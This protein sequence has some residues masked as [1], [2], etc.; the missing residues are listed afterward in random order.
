MDMDMDTVLLGTVL[1]ES[2]WECR[3]S[4]IVPAGIVRRTDLS[5]R[6]LSSIARARRTKVD[7][8]YVAYGSIRTMR[9]LRLSRLNE[10]VAKCQGLTFQ[11]TTI[12]ATAITGQPNQAASSSSFAFILTI[13]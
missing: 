5:T 3:C 11:K 12:T 4:L 1:T 10:L 9:K 13:V 2:A 8:R 6:G 7:F